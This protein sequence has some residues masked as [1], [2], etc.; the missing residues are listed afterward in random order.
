VVW[1]GDSYAP[2][3]SPDGSKI[4]FSSHSGTT[5]GGPHIKILDLVT[6]DVS[7][8]DSIIG[9]IPT[10]RPDGQ[11]IA[12]CGHTGEMGSTPGDAI[13]EVFLMN[14]DFSGLTQVTN[15]GSDVAW[16]SFSPDGTQL[17]FTG[18][19][20]GGPAIYIL[21]LTSGDV[22][23]FQPEANAAHWAP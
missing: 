1:Q 14:A 17:A 2:S 15:L 20:N 21:T 18:G 10:W 13:I 8:F 22:T 4:A 7:S 23:L 3:F 9:F 12:F 16:P 19:L 11:R 5:D 6:G